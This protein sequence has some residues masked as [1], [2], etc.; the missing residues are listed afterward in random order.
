MAALL[1]IVVLTHLEGVNSYH[2][3]SRPPGTAPGC[4]ATLVRWLQSTHLAPV[5][6][7]SRTLRRAGKTHLR[8]EAAGPAPEPQAT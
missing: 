2:V 3:V 4:A 5:C 1:I 6:R 8:K 7:P